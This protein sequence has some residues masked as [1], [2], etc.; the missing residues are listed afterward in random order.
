MMDPYEPR[1]K[2]VSSYKEAVAR[3][4]DASEGQPGRCG[5]G[6]QSTKFYGLLRGTP[7]ETALPFPAHES[8]A[9]TRIRLSSSRA[10]ESHRSIQ[11]R[12]KDYLPGANPCSGEDERWAHY[13][14]L[15]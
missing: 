13:T 1:G 6:W 7:A 9:V 3:V 5:F 15:D 11:S 8:L 4:S 10:W 14:C 12:Q 2:S